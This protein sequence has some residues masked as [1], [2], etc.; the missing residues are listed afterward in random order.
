MYPVFS[1]EVP[2]PFF[3]GQTTIYVIQSDP[4]TIIDTGI[5]TEESYEILLAGLSE[6][7]LSLADIGRIVLTHKH[8]DHIGNAGFVGQDRRDHHRAQRHDDGA[9]RESLHGLTRG[10]TVP[11]R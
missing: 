10:R 6:H 4:L 2:D 1:I 5:S 7:G 11:G 8:I 3:E 9:G